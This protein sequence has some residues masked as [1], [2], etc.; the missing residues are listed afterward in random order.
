MVKRGGDSLLKRGGDGLRTCNGD[1]SCISTSAG[2]S[3]TFSS[4]RVG[5]GNFP[6]RSG[7]LGR[8]ASLG[9][10]FGV[11]FDE[12]EY[13]EPLMVDS[14]LRGCRELVKSFAL[15]DNRR[16]LGHTLDGVAGHAPGM[17]LSPL[18]LVVVAD[19]MTRRLLPT[20]TM[21]TSMG[22]RAWIEKGCMKAN[23]FAAA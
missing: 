4:W 17:R 21:A 1:A 3:I 2:G 22:V 15:C 16:T 18:A 20:E 11:T 19:S 9:E 6:Y 14:H 5:K 10:R 8:L 12:E 13:A 23:I 7:V